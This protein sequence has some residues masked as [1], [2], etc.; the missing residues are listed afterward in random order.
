LQ[1]RQFQRQNGDIDT[2]F[3]RGGMPFGAKIEKLSRRLPFD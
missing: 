2:G 3:V 1:P